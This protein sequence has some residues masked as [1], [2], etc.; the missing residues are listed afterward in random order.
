MQS[1][2]RAARKRELSKSADTPAGGIKKIRLVAPASQ[3]KEPPKEP[4]TE[5][6]T[7]DVPETE[8]ETIDD[9]TNVAPGETRVVR[10]EREPV[11]RSLQPMRAKHKKI[12]RYLKPRENK[13][14]R[15]PYYDQVDREALRRMVK[16]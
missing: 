15:K 10:E 13:P 3:N 2:K 12:T 11:D 9:V 1:T 16:L 5:E 7:N 4:E 6:A 14:I 8:P